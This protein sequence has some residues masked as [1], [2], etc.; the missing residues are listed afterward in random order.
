MASIEWDPGLETGDALVDA[1]HKRIH[2]LFGDLE[3]SAD[4]S[5]EVMRV[6]DYLTEHVMMHF[7]TEEDLMEREA[8]PADARDAHIAEHQELTDGVRDKVLEFRIGELTSTGPLVE[9]LRDWLSSHVHERDR[10]LVEFVRAR[11][12]KAR[13]PEPWASRPSPAA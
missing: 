7:A 10:E 11:G 12:G 1:Q 2:Q 6:L 4:S 5:A 13:L 9:F 8:Y 3:T